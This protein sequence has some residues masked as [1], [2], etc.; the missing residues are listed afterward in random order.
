MEIWENEICCWNTSRRRVFPQLLRVLLNFHVIFRTRVQV[1][2]RGF[3]T[4]ENWWK[5]EA[6]GRV[7]LLFSS[8]WETPVKH[9]AQVFETASQSAPN[10]KEKKKRKQ[11]N[12]RTQKSHK[13]VIFAFFCLISAQ[14]VRIMSVFFTTEARLFQVVTICIQWRSAS[15]ENNWKF[16]PMKFDS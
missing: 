10:C 8:V 16:N 7:L 1:Y 2:Y 6:V 5:P 12:R 9:E 14:F 3:Q 4:R 11:K 13:H 15:S